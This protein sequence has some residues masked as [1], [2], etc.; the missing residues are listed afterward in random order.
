[1][2]IKKLSAMLLCLSLALFV[3]ACGNGGSKASDPAAE[4]ATDTGKEPAAEQVVLKL[5]TW[6]TDAKAQWSKII[7][8]FEKKY[9]NIK[10]ELDLLNE[11]GDSVASMQKL[12]LMAASNDQLDIVELPYTNYSQRADIGLLEP[13]DSFIE[14]DG[15]KYED[16]YLVDTHVNGK[17]YALPSSMQRWFV[18]MNKAMLDEAGLPV[19]TDWTWKDFEDYAKKLTKGDGAEKRYGAYLH[20]WPDYF[21]LQL[22]SKPSDNTFLKSDGT[23]NAKDPLLKA[24]LEMMKKMMYEDK[25]VNAYE[26]IISQKLAYRNQYFNRLAAMLPMGDWMVAESGG[27]DAIPATFLTAFAPLPKIEGES[28]HYSPVQPTYMAV[29]AK[30]KNKEAA[31]QFV[32]WYTSEGLEI[33][34]RV[35]SGWA[36]SDTD[37]LVDTIVNSSKDPSKIDL[38]SLKYTIKNTTPGTAPVPAKYADEAKNVVIPEAELYILNKQDIDK[39]ID[40]ID[41]KI[42][43]VVKNN[44]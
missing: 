42:S 18:I 41:Q 15:Y 23:S 7:P 29:A 36:K 38:E 26:D 14:K 11:K 20:N 34:G 3:A 35:F 37:K 16:E 25:S 32:R 17:I 22:M 8:E 6:Q 12:D 24:N 39:T 4:G 30:S 19:P 43:E 2:K 10:V 27:T 28:K 33:G 9:P 44:Q 31:Y 13:L 40:S 5:S 1:M 21:Q